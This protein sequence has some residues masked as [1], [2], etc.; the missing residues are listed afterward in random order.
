[1]N[2]KNYSAMPTSSA[3]LLT[4]QP[5]M[6]F[7]PLL[8]GRTPGSGRAFAR[9]GASTLSRASCICFFANFPTFRHETRR[10]L[11]WTHRTAP[12]LRSSPRPPARVQ[13]GGTGEWG[14]FMFGCLGGRK[15]TNGRLHVPD[16]DVRRRHSSNTPPPEAVRYRKFSCPKRG[17]A[18]VP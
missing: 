13:S 15:E 5:H 12:N 3:P 10:F 1:M 17:P 16:S 8:F 4:A 14:P 2:G 11:H 9:R 18:R 6:S 7:W